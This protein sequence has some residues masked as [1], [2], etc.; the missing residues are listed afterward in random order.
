MWL[1]KQGIPSRCPSPRERDWGVAANSAYAHFSNYPLSTLRFKKNFFWNFKIINVCSKSRAHTAISALTTGE[2]GPIDFNLKTPFC[3]N[4][5]Q[6]SG[7]LS[8]LSFST[9]IYIYRHM[10]TIQHCFVYIHFFIIMIYCPIMSYLLN[11]LELH[12]CR[13][14]HRSSSFLLT[15]V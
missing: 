14:I 9:F 4:V 2:K 13:H 10:E 3:L 1:W 6:F 8:G 11:E 12:K 5:C 7:H 15:A